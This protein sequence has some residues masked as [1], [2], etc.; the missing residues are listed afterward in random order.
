M[1]IDKYVKIKIGTKNIKHYK[2]LKY[3]VKIGITILVHVKDLLPTTKVKVKVKCDFCENIVE[4]EYKNYYSNYNN[5]NKF[6]C[7]AK[8]TQNKTK[9]SNLK[10]YGVEFVNQSNEIKNKTKNNSIKNIKK[11]NSTLLKNKP[12]YLNWILTKDIILTINKWNIEHFIH[13]GYEG[14]KINQKWIVPVEHLMKNS[15]VKIECKCGFC[16]KTQNITFQKYLENFNRNNFY[17]CK[18]CNNKTLKITM[19]NKYNVDNCCRLDT[20]INKKKKTCLD[21]YDNEYAIASKIV[22]NKIKQILLDK[23]GGHQIM[24]D[25]IKY[26][27]ISKG[28]E[29]K[30]RKGL[31]I[32]DDELSGWKLYRRNIRRLTE[33]N[34]KILLDNWNGLDFYDNEYIRD[35]FKLVHIDRRYPTLD[36]KISI[37]YGWQNNISEKDISDISNLCFTKRFINSIKSKLNFDDFD[38][39]N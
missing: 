29:T 21:K 38:M 1:I 36:H 15:G 6:S 26:K 10:R 35:N 34:R 12:E 20:C 18:G 2:E 31:I 11:Y 24:D 28:K 13:L 8:C 4:T 25:N 39:L 5:L 3:D 17:S 30:I 32:P 9:I 33:K 37:Y 7:C 19:M 14:L 23:Y 22:K 27:I 16:G